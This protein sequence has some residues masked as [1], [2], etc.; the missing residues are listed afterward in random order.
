MEK[1]HS[2]NVEFGVLRA[3]FMKS[4]IFWDRTPY[5]LLEVNRRFGGIHRLRLHNKR[6]RVR[7]QCES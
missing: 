4:I 6:S 5:T 7:N 2:E 1:I 3:V